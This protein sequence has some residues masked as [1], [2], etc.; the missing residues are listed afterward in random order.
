MTSG[1]SYVAILSWPIWTMSLLVDIYER[2]V[3]FVRSILFASQFIRAYAFLVTVE[4]ASTVSMKFL[5]RF[6]SYH[7]LGIPLDVPDRPVSGCSYRVPCWL[8][9]SEG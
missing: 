4:G 1:D 8:S 7:S 2:V 3:L 6:C 9:T 5:I